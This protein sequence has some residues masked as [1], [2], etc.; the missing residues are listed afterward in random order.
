MGTQPQLQVLYPNFYHYNDG[1][2]LF[3]ACKNNP[4]CTVLNTPPGASIPMGP[5]RL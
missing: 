1:L 5:M 2:H 3:N 4:N